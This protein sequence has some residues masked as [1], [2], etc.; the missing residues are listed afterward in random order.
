LGLFIL[1]GFS[2]IPIVLLLYFIISLIAK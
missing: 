2:S 1:F